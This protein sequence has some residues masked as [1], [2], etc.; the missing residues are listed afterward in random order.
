MPA[1]T[2]KKGDGVIVEFKRDAGGSQWFKVGNQISTGLTGRSTDNIDKTH[3]ESEKGVKEYEAGQKEPGTVPFEYHAD[4][5]TDTL[6]TLEEM[7]EDG[8]E[9]S[10]RLNFTATGWNKYKQGRGYLQNPGDMTVA[11]N[12]MIGGTGTIQVTG[13][14][15]FVNAT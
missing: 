4:L 8:E 10:W 12:A 14:T 3:L 7:W 6:E 5:A 9:F 13:L 11:M 15:E 1:S 2:G